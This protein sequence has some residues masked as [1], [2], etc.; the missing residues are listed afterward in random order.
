MPQLDHVELWLVR[1]GQTEEN[2]REILSGWIEAQL[3]PKGIAQAKALKNALKDVDFDGIFSSPL[4]RA[5]DTARLAGKTPVCVDAI[6]EF[7][8]G[9]YDGKKIADLPKDWIKALY[10]FKDDFETPHGENIAAVS[11]RVTPFLHAL[12]NGRYL[13]FCHG[14]VIR[15]I[16]RHLGA[17]KF[18]E[19]G[20]I[21]VVDWTHRKIL[22]QIF[23]DAAA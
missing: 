13:L 8:F 9:D 6:K 10:T 20:T 2:A 23:P 1:H 18:I 16:T 14:G 22:N 17:D 11:A 12:P 7:C 3:S 4:K 19:N 15:T 5:Q 21:L